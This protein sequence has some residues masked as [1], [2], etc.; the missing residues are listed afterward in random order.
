MAKTY[1]TISTFTS[2]Q[3][4]TAA[5]MNE[6]GT[7]VNNSRVPPL[8]LLRKTA[9]QACNNGSFTAITFGAG[10]EL[11]DTDGMHST[12]TNTAR[13]TP[14]TA[15][16][17]LFTGNVYLSAFPASGMAIRGF[18]NN[19]QQIFYSENSSATIGITGSAMEYMNGTTDF[20]T[21]EV[22]YSHSGNLT[23]NAS[24]FPGFQAAFIGQPS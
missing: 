11:Y 7:N 24:V 20:V 3:V 1:N 22:F 5:Q 13:I 12:I 18:K 10:E 21:L 15:G 14:T 17:Y 2:G 4:L 6:I 23:T 16:I 19:S 9:T 8:C